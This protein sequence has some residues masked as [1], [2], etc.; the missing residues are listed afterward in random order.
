MPFAG[1]QPLAASFSLLGWSNGTAAPR[2][3]S[4]PSPGCPTE[5]TLILS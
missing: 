2:Q 3:K 5:G 4:P 1:A